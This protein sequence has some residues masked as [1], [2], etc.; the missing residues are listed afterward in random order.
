M[1]VVIGGCEKVG[2]TTF[3]N[4]L[5]QW[6]QENRG[7]PT[8]YVHRPREVN[9]PEIVRKDLVWAG[10][11]PDDL[12]IFDRF[13]PSDLVYRTWDGKTSEFPM[14]AHWMDQHYGRWVDKIGVRILLLGDPEVLRQRRTPDDIPID[15]ALEQRLYEM[16]CPYSWHRIHT[17]H[18]TKDSLIRRW[19][20]IL[21]ES[22]F[23]RKNDYQS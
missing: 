21:R 13:Y 8:N 23:W 22:N 6:W 15:P 20:Q 18:L 2:K 5:I 3:S 10:N 4:L 1:L 17:T 19:E 11:N 12:I 14:N 9:V 7:T 16:V